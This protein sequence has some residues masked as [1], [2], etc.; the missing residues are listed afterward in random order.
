MNI[1]FTKVL[2]ST[3][4]CGLFAL[5]SIARTTI[6]DSTV[7][8]SDT[9]KTKSSKTAVD[10]AEKPRVASVYDLS[11]EELLKL[12]PVQ[13]TARKRTELIKDVPASVSV[14]DQNQ[15]DTYTSAARDIRSL[16]SRSPSLQIESSF[17][18]LFP[19]FYLR[20][21]GNTDFDINAS[22]PVS[23]VFDGVVQENPMLR[24]FPLFDMQRV[25]VLRGP[26]GTLFGRNT[27]AGV[28]KLESVRP[29]PG[30][31]SDASLS[32]G[33][34]NTIDFRGAVNSQLSNEL[35]ARIS[36]IY[37]QRDNWIDNA[38]PGFEQE[39]VLGG[40]DEVA[41]RLQLNYKTNEKLNW[42][43]N[44]HARDFK[45][46][47]AVFR[48]NILSPG[49]NRLNDN[50]DS[51]TVFLD[52]A[53]R[54]E[55]TLVNQGGSVS[56]DY[57]FDDLLM[58]IISGYESVET[59]S[60]GDVDGGYG[61]V[62]TPSSGPGVISF[63]A[64][65]ASNIP[66][67]HQYT[68][69]IRWSS[70]N[71]GNFGYQFG[72]FIFNEDL[73]IKNQSYDTLNSGLLNGLATQHQETDAW[74]MFGTLDYAIA[75]QFRMTTGIRYGSDKKRYFTERL[76]SP[77]GAGALAPIHVSK[78][79]SH[80]SW[81]VSAVYQW[82]R[83][84]NLYYRIAKAFRA[85][86]IQGR[87]IFGDAVT[88]AKSEQV[89]SYEVGIKTTFWQGQGKLN[90]AMF[91]YN[92]EDQQ[93]TA[94]GGED[95]NNRLLNVA[96]TKSYGFELEAEFSLNQHWRIDSGVS[97]TES[98]IDDPSLSVSVCPLCT[99]TDPLN[100]QGF[101]IIDGNHLPHTPH[102]IAFLLL[103][104][105]TEWQAGLLYFQT[106]WSYRSE[107]DFFL[108]QSEEFKG[109]ALLEGGLKFGYRWSKNKYNYEVS[110][111]ARN[112]TN[113]QEVIGGVD[114]NN[115]TGIVNEPRYI[116]LEFKVGL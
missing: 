80:L 83:D 104:Y 110:L 33:S 11:L 87:V 50:F 52:A 5:P 34:S 100:A 37:Q 102:W 75:N 44:F 63:P 43:I 82:Q 65:N 61:A 1:W 59:F 20:G 93:V 7:E 54:T 114:F 27:P 51:D 17:D 84:A 105:Q 22:Q 113:E 101:A 42:L 31:S 86:S 98:K 77:I 74:A 36:L 15:L 92:I 4:L 13:V 76:I 3:A 26:Q 111:L 81:D 16:S 78:S 29:Q 55:Q 18:R 12:K 47:P 2:A 39:S 45:G 108:Y 90:A 94:V 28:I 69:E 72:A 79:D 116:G 8:S 10:P 9:E 99:I 71:Q 19:R 66:K 58:T 48:A 14:L 25:E 40:F 109:P 60:I 21:L 30:S 70:S 73:L 91:S 68:Q 107:V 38:A 32:V 41:M 112:I 88:T 115:L 103:N 95:I 56:V 89:V 6:T 57:Q 67:H 96:D 106:D 53:Q 64:E 62:F 97:F 35:M 24:G 85:P 46:A 23:L 49:S